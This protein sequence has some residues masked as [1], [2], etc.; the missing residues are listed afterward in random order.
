MRYGVLSDTHG[1]LHPEVP[2]FFAEV[3]E[4]FHAGD[5]GA[6]RILDELEGIAPVVAVR[7]NTDHGPYAERL[8]ERTTLV[9]EGKRIVLLHG[10]LVAAGRPAILL[11]ATRAER[12]DLVIFGHTHVPLQ[13]MLEGVIFFNPGAAGRPRFGSRPTVGLLEITA[14]ELRLRHQSLPVPYPPAQR[15]RT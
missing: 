1:T 15:R 11:E 9:R 8:P 13:E 6:E 2:A 5:V 7:G 4:I 10:H 14:A 12:P 3:K